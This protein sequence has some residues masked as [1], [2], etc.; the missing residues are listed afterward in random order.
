MARRT[1]LMTGLAGTLGQLTARYLHRSYNVVGVDRRP[2]PSRA[3]DVEHVRLDIRRK[4]LQDVFRRYRP[5]TVV[6][7]GVMHDPRQTAQEHHTFNL[8]G[9][10]RLLEH[11]HKYGVKKIVVLS[12]ASVYG[13]GGLNH[14]FIGEDTPLMGAQ[15]FPD[16]RDLIAVDMIAQGHIWKHHEIQTVI[17][18]PVHILGRV[19][20]APSNYL[21]LPTAPTLLGFDPMIQVI[22]EQDVVRAI[23]RAIEKRVRGVFNIVGPGQLPLSMA[24]EEV[25]ARRLP[26]PEIL[27]RP[28]L[29]RLYRLRLTNF[30]AP[31]LD[32]IKYSLLV[33]GGR[34]RK[35]LGFTAEHSLRDS[36]RAVLTGL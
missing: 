7:L 32:H 13:P 24:L 26:L 35:E 29:H 11:C 10:T 12:S 30:P 2:L 14:G 31:E 20:N 28:L 15:K 22:H 19:R 25:G 3:K 1:V 34:A 27:A 5:D 21:R 23:E 8:L 17:L 6:H 9:I 36:L 4:A 33:D 18:R 16:L